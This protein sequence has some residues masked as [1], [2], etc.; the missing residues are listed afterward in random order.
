MSTG[1]AI[2][3]LVL[4]VLVALGFPTRA[5]LR[6]AYTPP[7]GPHPVVRP[8]L[9]LGRWRRKQR[10]RRRRRHLKSVGEARR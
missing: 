9:A 1:I 3:V 6:R 7:R 8:F 4:L 5:R 2:V 10:D